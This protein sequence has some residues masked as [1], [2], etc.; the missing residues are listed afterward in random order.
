M[1]VLIVDDEVIIQNAMINVLPWEEH[2]FQ[3]LPPASSGEEALQL[4]HK[5]HPEIIISDIRMQGMTGLEFIRCLKAVKY[6]KEVIIL[7]GFDEF[8]YV[9][10]AIKQD[11]SDY[12][13]KTSSPAEILESVNKAR[14]RLAETKRFIQLKASKEEQNINRKLKTLLSRPLKDELFNEFI[15]EN[16]SLSGAVYELIL[17]DKV[18]DDKT[19]FTCSN[20]WNSYLYG[21]WLIYQ[22]QTLIIIKRNPNL[23]DDYLL[24]MAAKQVHAIYNEPLFQSKTM[25]TLN[26]LSK[27]FDSINRITAYKWLFPNEIII[28]IEDLKTRKGIS[29]IDRFKQH[30]EELIHVIR[31]G[32]K[33]LLREWINRFVHWLFE[34]PMATPNSIAHYVQHLYYNV[35][36]YLEKIY[37]LK[38]NYGSGL[39]MTDQFFS[40]PVALLMDI[41][42]QLQQLIK[43][44]K[45]GAEHYV[46]LAI[47]YMERNIGKFITLQDVANDIHIHPNYL[48]E[49]IRKQ[50][51]QSFTELLTEKRLNKSVEYLLFTKETVG[52]VAGLVGY[53]DHK[54]FTKIF[55]KHFKLTPSAYRRSV[56]K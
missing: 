36:R 31:T 41:F 25:T 21:K 37:Q 8:D 11:V 56:E 7:S 35:I 9:Q 15:R 51:G 27:R 23:S 12:L 45:E 54:Y 5:H 34:H 2:S 4:V 16:K 55:K 28:D 17:I 33:R 14:T 40:N 10:E 46:E 53:K 13:L 19:F 43:G 20:K 49:V 48:S 29:Y 18:M 39:L 30:E 22:E 50:T 32:E 52:Q 3:V 38:G 24:Q 6:P 44:Q 47:S 26:L 1:K 42:S